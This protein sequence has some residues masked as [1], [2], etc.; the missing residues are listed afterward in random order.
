MKS[1]YIKYQN[2]KTDI[3]VPLYSNGRAFG[4]LYNPQKEASIFA[5]QENLK[6]SGLIIVA[7]Y[8]YGL[9]I[10][11]IK[12]LYPHAKIIVIEANE[13]TW[14][15]LN[16]A[17]DNAD[18][19]YKA[20]PK[21]IEQILLNVYFPPLDGN[22]SFVS[23]RSWEQENKT[24]TTMLTSILKKTLQIIAADI[25]TQ[26]RFGKIWHNNIR[27]NLCLC[28]TYHKTLIDFKHTDFPTQKTAILV[29]AGPGLEDKI[30]QLQ[31][32]AT[33]YYIVATDTAYPILI[34]YN[35]VADAVV[36]ID[37]QFYSIKHFYTKIYAKTLFIWDISGNPIPIRWAAQ[38]KNPI[39][40]FT[41]SHPLCT[42]IEFYYQTQY[43]RNFFYTL[44]AGRGS[45]GIVALD[46][47]QKAGFQKI[48]TMGLDFAYYNG[49]AYAQGS[50]LEKTYLINSNYLK[51]LENL[52]CFLML[53][54]PLIHLS[55]ALN[56][57]KYTTVLLSEYKQ[58]FESMQKNKSTPKSNHKIIINYAPYKQKFPS[59]D[60]F[61]WY[62]MQLRN[63]K[64][65]D[66]SSLNE[67]VKNTL[68][69]YFAWNLTYNKTKTQ[70][71]TL[72]EELSNR[73]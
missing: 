49:K 44:N 30:I 52:F 24:L 14:N 37:P 46:F 33:Q 35:I 19:F 5:Q 32:H 22:F 18:N 2:A 39:L 59:R 62:Y 25:A 17:K 36:S 64:I 41:S 12:K 63:F 10:S 40:F 23:V 45:V 4:S 29:G 43:K 66:T 6:N 68:L 3:K 20:T 38:K 8:G 55:S 57:K 16:Y 67:M 53:K 13:A 26:S 73:L 51:S 1:I 42:L 15:F 60:F 56:Q 47:V 11:E 50:Y 58:S 65:N 7:G 27:K 48:E 21:T 9:H 71:T 34:H 31:A 70:L 28:E 72:A 54:T 61:K 69:P